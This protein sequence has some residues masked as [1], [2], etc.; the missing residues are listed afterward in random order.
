MQ[1]SCR[2]AVLKLWRGRQID[3]L[4]G[5]C[6]ER[7]DVT[8][9]Q[10]EALLVCI[11]RLKRTQDVGETRDWQRVLQQATNQMNS[12]G[13][14]QLHGLMSLP[15]EK[16]IELGSV[17]PLC[18]LLEALPNEEA[19]R[20][21]ARALPSVDQLIQRTRRATRQRAEQADDVQDPLPNLEPDLQQATLRIEDLGCCSCASTIRH[22]RKHCRALFCLVLVV[23]S[24]LWIM[25]VRTKSAR[26]CPASLDYGTWRDHQLGQKKI[27]EQ[28]L[29]EHS[30]LNVD[31][32]ISI[33]NNQGTLT[34]AQFEVQKRKQMLSVFVPGHSC[35]AT[36]EAGFFPNYVLRRASE[37][38]T[39]AES[40]TCF[41]D[42]DSKL[43][44]WRHGDHDSVSEDQSQ[45]RK[46]RNPFS[47]VNPKP[48]QINADAI[49]GNVR[50]DDQQ[51][52]YEL[53]VSPGIDYEI[54]VKIDDGRNTVK[55]G[56]IG[57]SVVCIYNDWQQQTT[58][59]EGTRQTGIQIS[60]RLTIQ[61][62]G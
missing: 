14:K 61:I 28:G 51:V 60:P 7:Y 12:V 38:K 49:T 24:A 6:E 1:C 15:A 39:R 54:T 59:L 17:Q 11:E 25:D 20:R 27:F 9:E 21:L 10:L 41:T 19:L 53:T 4:E 50:E 30:R 2:R 23:Y 22:I 26:C 32:C 31:D 34:Q 52:W 29:G 18:D 35:P 33:H 47:C 5:V 57:D 46:W 44:Y 37:V 3:S 8:Q 55:Q 42:K 48:L 58:D 45:Q 16:S 40:Y 62:D 56:Y 13:M 43:S 36:C